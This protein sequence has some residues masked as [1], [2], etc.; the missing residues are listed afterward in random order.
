V[1]P[2]WYGIEPGMGAFTNWGK[3]KLTFHLKAFVGNCRIRIIDEQFFE[4]T[5][6]GGGLEQRT[7][8]S[9]SVGNSVLKGSYMYGSSIAIG[10]EKPIGVNSTVGINVEYRSQVYSP[11]KI[12]RKSINNAYH[13]LGSV[14]PVSLDNDVIESTI[15]PYARRT[16]LFES[17][18]FGISWKRYLRSQKP[19]NKIAE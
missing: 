10:L 7:Q 3:Y 15:D 4:G 17:F 19:E 12:L 6:S 11:S 8:Y 18:A 16:Y 5:R 1:S 2:V 14:V 9:H 13:L